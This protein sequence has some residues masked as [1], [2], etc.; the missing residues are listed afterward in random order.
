[1]P[2]IECPGCSQMLELDAGTGPL[3][4]CPLCGTKFNWKQGPPSSPSARSSTAVFDASWYLTIPDGQR[5]GPT[6]AEEIIGWIQDGRVPAGSMVWRKEFASWQPVEA[7][8][9]FAR[10]RLSPSGAITGS[11]AG[12]GH[13]D[14]R[15]ATLNRG[16]A[17]RR[18]RWSGLAIAGFVIAL[19]CGCLAPLSLILCAVAM[20]ATGRDPSLRGRGL[21]IAGLVLSIISLALWAMALS[22]GYRPY[23]YR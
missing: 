18:E 19:A 20:S 1:M 15:H 9:P 3:A 22:G 10:Y 6:S 16:G 8:E 2:T 21:A 14:T 12:Y 11:Q 17:R 23:S 4:T 5:F 13:P 7:T